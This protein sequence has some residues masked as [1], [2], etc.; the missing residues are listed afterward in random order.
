MCIAID[1]APDR[2]SIDDMRIM[3]TYICKF[4]SDDTTVARWCMSFFFY[5]PTF[6]YSEFRCRMWSDVC[7]NG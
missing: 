6:K 5:F 4:E 2:L 1:I 7:A 3:Y